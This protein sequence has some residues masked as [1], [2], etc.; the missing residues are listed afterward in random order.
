MNAITVATYMAA[1]MIAAATAVATAEISLTSQGL[2]RPLPHSQRA[3]RLAA[4]QLRQGLGGGPAVFSRDQGFSK[5]CLS[6][7][8][9]RYNE[10][11]ILHRFPIE[12]QP[13]EPP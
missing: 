12:H 2:P 11:D 6:L 4:V 7:V 1:A 3:N 10:D 9:S 5:N 13:S 8:G